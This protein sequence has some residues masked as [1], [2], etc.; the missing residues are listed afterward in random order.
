MGDGGYIGLTELMCNCN[1][2]DRWYSTRSFRAS[3]ERMFFF[4]LGFQKVVAAE[5]FVIE[6]AALEPGYG[7]RGD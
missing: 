2:S 6:G 7:Y 1:G 3:H 4:N 5:A